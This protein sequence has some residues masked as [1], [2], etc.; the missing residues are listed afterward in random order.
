MGIGLVIGMWLVRW[1][2]FNLPQPLLAQPIN[3]PRP[4]Q[5]YTFDN[6]RQKTYEPQPIEMVEMIASEPEY[7]SW[8]YMIQTEEGKVSGQLNL[9][10]GNGKFPVVVM[11][12]GYVDKET[13][14]TGIGTKNAAAAL[15]R[16]G[17]VTVA[18]D[19]LGYGSS[20]PQPESELHERVV[21]PA[22]VL[23][24]FASL[25]NI[26]QAD[27]NRVFLWGH[28]NGGQIALSVLEISGQDIP[29]TLWAPVSKPFPYS[30]LY[31]TDATADHGKYLRKL[32][33][34]FE[35]LYDAEQ[36]SISNYFEWIEAPIQVHQ[37]T[38]DNAVPW[39]WSHELVNALKTTGKD[40]SLF[41]YPGA[42]HNLQPNWDLVMARD[43]KFFNSFNK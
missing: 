8:L 20:D 38:A 36:F 29:T 9:P 34:E 26:P 21:K 2:G 42:D 25:A 14:Q 31:F 17:Y 24:V 37:G 16:Q 39:N 28:S 19:F 32:L 43:I 33:F 5:K 10:L 6:L 13:Y 3:R 35:Q 27:T 12:R 22:T 11:L 40:S 23:Q 1:T 4:L 7:I 41:T 15:A 18:P 30:I